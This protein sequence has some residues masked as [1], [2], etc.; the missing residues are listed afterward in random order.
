MQWASQDLRVLF[1]FFLWFSCVLESSKHPFYG[2]GATEFA[3]MI[4]FRDVADP[5]NFPHS[6]VGK[7]IV[8]G[9]DGT[10]KSQ[11]SGTFISG[12]WVLTNTHVLSG[13]DVN[14][15]IIGRV[16]VMFYNHD[17]SL[18]VEFLPQWRLSFRI[19]ME[20]EDTNLPDLAIVKLGP[21]V[22]YGRQQSAWKSWE[23]N[24]WDL[25]S[26]FQQPPNFA[27]FVD[28]GQKIFTIHYPVLY[29]TNQEKHISFGSVVWEGIT[30]IHH[31][32]EIRLGSSGSPVFSEDRNILAVN[33]GRTV[34]PNIFDAIKLTRQSPGRNLVEDMRR[35]K[36]ILEKA[37]TYD[38]LLLHLGTRDNT[39][40]YT[41][42]VQQI[43]DRFNN[44]LK[45]IEE[46]KN[47][48]LIGLPRDF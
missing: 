17:E 4:P 33:V 27:D 22:E 30:M 2:T 10:I 26:N 25:F 23:C 40:D 3:R 5:I 31:T 47:I 8:Q 41:K 48:L 42:T 12:G 19:E 9:E 29:P 20:H 6:Y 43:L 24:E 11:G 44:D 28:L 13:I 21:Q 14:D 34:D 1:L 32:A 35:A 36:K 39:Q 37:K 18:L 16:G 7:I 46:E 45:E 38:R 15:P